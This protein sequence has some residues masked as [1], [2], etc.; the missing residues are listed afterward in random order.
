MHATKSVGVEPIPKADIGVLLV[1]GIGDHK[2]GETLTAFGEPLIDSLREW[3]RGTANPESAENPNPELTEARLKAVR[4]EAESPAY[5][6]MT[7]SAIEKAAGL[8]LSE[9]WLLCEAWWGES[10]QPPRPLRLL[11]W[12][13]TR[14]PILIFW[15]FFLGF[16]AR[17]SD[18]SNV[19]HAS[20]SRMVYNKCKMILLAYWFSVLAIFLAAICQMVMTTAT[21]LLVIPIG[22]WRQAVANVARV[23]TLT[24]GDSYVLLEHDIQRTALV[25]RVRKSL[26]WLSDRVKQ[27]VVIAHSQGAAIAHEALVQ[28]KLDK[29]QRFITVGSGLEK[30]HFLRRTRQT[31]KGLLSSALLCPVLGAG[32]WLLWSG[33]YQLSAVVSF[34]GFV[35][36]VIALASLENYQ[37]ELTKRI[38]SLRLKQESDAPFWLDINATHDLIPM[39]VGSLLR[40]HPFVTGLEISNKRSFLHDHIDYFSNRIGFVAVLWMS[41]SEVSRL[42]PFDEDQSRM[43]EHHVKLHSWYARVLSLTWHST[44]IAAVLAVLVV[45]QT[46]TQF[47]DTVL[48]ILKQLPFT[49]TLG[50]TRFFA[51]VIKSFEWTFQGNKDGFWAV[52]LGVLILAIGLLLWRI[53]FVGLWSARAL[54]RWRSACRGRDVL[55]TTGNRISCFVSCVLFLMC[56]CLPFLVV[57]SLMVAPAFANLAT[58]SD[59]IKGVVAFICFALGLAFALTMP[60]I[61]SSNLKDREIPPLQIASYPFV[62]IVAAGAL[63]KTARWFWPDSFGNLPGEVQMVTAVSLFAALVWQGYFLLNRASLGIFWTI[64]VVGAPMLCSL[65][66]FLPMN[67]LAFARAYFLTT[68]TL[69]FLAFVVVNQAFYVECV[70]NLW[71]SFVNLRSAR[72]INRDNKPGE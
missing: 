37:S 42:R 57:I 27:V 59:L 15:H 67:S 72:T 12:L 64:T 32:F 22:K 36:A 26:S 49:E 55:H 21:A 8:P 10:V 6:V 51:A 39:G 61:Y 47:G 54:V 52:V 53:S 60:W 46:V 11:A 2:E 56:G 58:A 19:K 28:T 40:T 38:P 69:L 23:L 62:A 45:K 20:I 48:I 41:L 9:S 3:L 30:L 18:K 44:W 4:N 70:T 16:Q 14:G 66:F 63:L 65:G 33:Q 7:I 13:W 5:A 31:R 25:A 17:S 71:H 50:A 29:V 1:H 24:L 35:L 43:L 68:A 34:T